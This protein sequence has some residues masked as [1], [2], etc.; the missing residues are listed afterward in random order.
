[1]IYSIP[2]RGR[3][4]ATTHTHPVALHLCI[5]Q[6]SNEPL[7]LE[8]TKQHLLL[9]SKISCILPKESKN[10]LTESSSPKDKLQLRFEMQEASSWMVK[11]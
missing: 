8:T 11:V 9:I 2:G 5:E 4:A 7:S 1:M 6:Y 3:S 10:K